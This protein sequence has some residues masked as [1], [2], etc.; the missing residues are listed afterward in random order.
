MNHIYYEWQLFIRHLKFFFDRV[1]TLD[2]L[3]LYVKYDRVVTFDHLFLVRWTIL[4]Y[5]KSNCHCILFWN[6]P[7]PFSLDFTQKIIITK[8]NIHLMTIYENERV[9]HKSRREFINKS[10][11]PEGISL[12]T[13]HSPQSL[14]DLNFRVFACTLS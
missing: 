3:F 10:P 6:W 4:R 7:K 11:S 8:C 5:L 9:I 14:T 12:I 2:R 1:V 13:F